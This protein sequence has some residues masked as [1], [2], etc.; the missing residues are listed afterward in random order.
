MLEF[1]ETPKGIGFQGLILCWKNNFKEEKGLI[2]R[3]WETLLRKIEALLNKTDYDNFWN[4]V[5]IA[6]IITVVVLI[7][8]KAYG[9]N[10]SFLL[11]PNNKSLQI[12]YEVSEENIHELNLDALISK[13]IDEKNYRLAVRYQYLK[14][15]KLLS[16]KQIISW[17]PEKTNRSYLYELNDMQKRNEFEKITTLF[18]YAWYGDKPV[19]AENFEA[20]SHY[21]NNFNKAI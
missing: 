14:T 20:G 2:A 13:A 16:D 9:K 21:F 8:K 10:I 15:L 7:L 6:V 4:Y 19:N 5:Y 18:E 1:A 3:L 11:R 17:R 12:D